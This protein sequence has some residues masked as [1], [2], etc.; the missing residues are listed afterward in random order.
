MPAFKICPDQLIIVRC[1]VVACLLTTT[2]ASVQDFT[3]N[4]EKSIAI[5]YG[6]E[7][8]FKDPSSS[9]MKIF[10]DLN[11]KLSD[12]NSALDIDGN[13]KV[14][15]HA[16]ISLSGHR[17]CFPFHHQAR[18]E[19]A[20]MLERYKQH[21]WDCNLEAFSATKSIDQAA[22]GKI[23]VIAQGGRPPDGTLNRTL[24]RLFALHAKLCMDVY[25]KYYEKAIQEVSVGD[26]ERVEKYADCILSVADPEGLSWRNRLHEESGHL[27]FLMDRLPLA[28]ALVRLAKINLL[29]SIM[30]EPHGLDMID[31]VKID[32][33]AGDRAAF[34]DFARVYAGSAC[35]NYIQQLGPIFIPAGFEITARRRSPQA[36]DAEKV[37]EFNRALLNYRA[38]V[39][40]LA[41]D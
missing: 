40:T 39:S 33:M 21:F 32:H 36:N 27:L 18:V 1:I 30:D 22:Q 17:I 37:S 10:A 11:K 25:M 41:D 9:T 23:L 15:D 4:Y 16:I 8:Y 38:C 34:R 12:R 3:V 7:K 6:W 26:R 29:E 2:S 13:M 35:R 5:S 24:Y 19:V 14:L 28:P 31:R 20:S